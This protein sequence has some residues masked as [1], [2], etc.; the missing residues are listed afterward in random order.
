MPLPNYVTETM[1][2]STKIRHCHEFA[3][4]AKSKQKTTGRKHRDAE[5]HCWSTLVARSVCTLLTDWWQWSS[6]GNWESPSSS[7]SWPV[8]VVSSEEAYR[9][10]R[11]AGCGWKRWAIFQGRPAWFLFCFGV[12]FSRVIASSA[13]IL[14]ARR[15]VYCFSI[16]LWNWWFS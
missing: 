6:N 12:E 5:K 14:S 1:R 8:R 3:G 16:R 2:Q 9:G 11:L 15:I 13:C 7:S 10:R 4:N